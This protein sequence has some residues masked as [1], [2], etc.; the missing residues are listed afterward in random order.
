MVVSTVDS[1]TGRG[2][3]SILEEGEGKLESN[4]RNRVREEKFASPKEREAGVGR[5]KNLVILRPR[6]SCER[7]NFLKWEIS[8]FPLQKWNPSRKRC[9]TWIS[10]LGA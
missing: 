10:S 9:C 8:S 2:S 6:W 4:W 7:A 3:P 5:K 1:D